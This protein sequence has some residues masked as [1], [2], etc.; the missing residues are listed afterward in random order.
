MCVCVCVCIPISNDNGGSPLVYLEVLYKEDGGFSVELLTSRNLEDLPEH[1]LIECLDVA[2][3]AA[4]SAQ[5]M[6]QHDVIN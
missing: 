6:K 3:L 4:V 5:V 1:L 2:D